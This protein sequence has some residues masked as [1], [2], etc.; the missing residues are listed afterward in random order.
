MRR[1]IGG[2]DAREGQGDFLRKFAIGPRQMDG[3]R[4]GLRIARHPAIQRA[5][6]RRFQARIGA[7]DNI[8]PTPHIRPEHLE[9]AAIAR[10]HIAHRDVLPG[11]K[12]QPPPQM[13]QVGFAAIPDL[14]QR[15]RQIGH[16]LQALL[17][18][19]FAK[20][21]QPILR[22][23]I[24]LPEI[25]FI[26]DLRID[27]AGGLVGTQMQFAPPMRLAPADAGKQNRNQAGF[28]S[29]GKNR[30]RSPW[31][32]GYA[33]RVPEGSKFFFEKRRSPPCQNQK[34]S[35]SCNLACVLRLLSKKKCFRKR[36]KN[37]G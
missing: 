9:H 23:K 11:R 24:Y 6:L 12:F 8:V 25:A 15:F 33:W 30:R 29:C 4:A 37:P 3:H 35:T 5:I 32:R 13:K 21:Q 27:R 16:H 20:P 14:R 17:A 26:I 34:T 22:H 18:L 31:M 1:R 2:Q 36:G 10:H 7:H 19:G 28:I